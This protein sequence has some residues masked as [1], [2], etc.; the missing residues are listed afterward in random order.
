MLSQSDLEKLSRAIDVLIARGD[1]N[2]SVKAFLMDSR[3]VD[4]V[5]EA[6]SSRILFSYSK[7]QKHYYVDFSSLPTESVNSNDKPLQAEKRKGRGKGK[8]VPKKVLTFA[9]E[10]EIDDWLREMSNNQERS[11]SSYIRMILKREMQSNGGSSDV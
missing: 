6:Y 3:R 9:V 5:F 2:S 11:V 7:R 4:R 8:G 1:F 10:P